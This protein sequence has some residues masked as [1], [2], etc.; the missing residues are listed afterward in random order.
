MSFRECGVWTDNNIID[1]SWLINHNIIMSPPSNQQ[2][3]CFPGFNYAPLQAQLIACCT[4]ILWLRANELKERYP[5]YIRSGPRSP[6]AMPQG[7]T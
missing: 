4:V 1:M 7:V 5:Q 6:L 3:R 2:S